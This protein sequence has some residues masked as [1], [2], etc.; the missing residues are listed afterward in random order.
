LRRVSAAGLRLELHPEVW[1]SPSLRSFAA[2]AHV[3]WGRPFVAFGP[4]FVA[5][6]STSRPNGADRLAELLVRDGFRVR[7]RGMHDGL[8]WVVADAPG[9]GSA[10]ADRVAATVR[11]LGR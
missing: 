3:G 2:R 7:A 11:A 5:A 9:G 1:P 8:A 10:S 4:P 6:A